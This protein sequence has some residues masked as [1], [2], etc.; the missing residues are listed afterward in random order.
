MCTGGLLITNRGVL[1]LAVTVLACLTLWTAIVT[2]KWLIGPEVLHIPSEEGNFTVL[3]HPS[4]GIYNRCKRMGKSDY[5]CGNFDLDALWTDSSVFPMPWKITMY[6]MNVGTLLDG[7]TLFCMYAIC[8]RVHK[9]FGFS[10][11]K[12]V[13]AV[14]CL[15]ALMVLCGFLAYPFGWGARRVKA[16]CGPDAEPFSPADC[17][18]GISLYIGVAGVLLAFLCP[19]MCLK[20]EQSYYSSKAQRRIKDGQK[21]VCII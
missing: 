10:M 12:F 2:P 13:C 15:A 6:L 9:Y 7:L 4:V 17:T 18:L 8:C 21:L 20:A 14:Q 16:L 11:H 5:N 19:V 3:R 1:W